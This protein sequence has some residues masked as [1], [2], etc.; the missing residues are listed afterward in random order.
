MAAVQSKQSLIVILKGN[1]SKLK[2]Y[3]VAKLSIFGSFANN[4]P[5]PESDIDFLVEFAPDKKN[6]DNFINLSFYLEEL[7]GRRVEL[8]T[9]QSLSK[10]IGPHILKNA[11]DVAI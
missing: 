6:Y 8:I 2:S 9:P 4:K 3:G 5:T 7:L 11:E 1:S 10:Y